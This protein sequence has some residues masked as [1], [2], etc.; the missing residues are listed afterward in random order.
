MRTTKVV[1]FFDWSSLESSFQQ[2]LIIITTAFTVIRVYELSTLV[3]IRFS[4]IEYHFIKPFIW[5]K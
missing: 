4:N 2:D 5:T 3:Y 1:F